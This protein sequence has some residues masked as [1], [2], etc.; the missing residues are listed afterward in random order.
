MTPVNE[1]CDKIKG[2]W[3]PEEDKRLRNLVQQHGAR[4]WSMISRSIPGRSGKSCRLRWC[5]QLSPEIEHRPFTAEEDVIILNAH[6]K[7]GNRWAKIARLINGRTDNAIKNHWNAT[8]KRKL[9]KVHGGEERPAQVLRRSESGDVAVAMMNSL[10]VSPDSLPDVCD[11]GDNLNFYLPV[12]TFARQVESPPEVV[13]DEENSEGS[14]TELTLRLPGLYRDSSA[15]E[16]R[17]EDALSTLSRR[18]SI[19]SNEFSTPLVEVKKATTSFCPEL[20]A[21]MQDMIR[22]EVRNYFSGEQL[23]LQHSVFTTTLA[24]WCIG[25]TVIS[26]RETKNQW[27]RDDPAFIVICTLLLLVSTVAYCAAYD[28]GTGHAVFVVILVLLFHFLVAGAILA[29]S[30][31]LYAFDVHCNSFFPVFVLLYVI[32]YFLS[33][34]LVAHGFVPVLL[35]NLLFMAALSYY[36]YLNYL[37]YDVLPFLERTTL[38]LYPIG[39]VIVLSPIFDYSITWRREEEF[40]EEDSVDTIS[41]FGYGRNVIARQNHCWFLVN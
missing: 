2:P 6:A 29:S 35:S 37:G 28:H 30:C 5:N 4:N 10:R 16:T 20:L 39:I 11:S 12:K 19:E 9:E 18:S 36:H 22:M 41:I 38:F 15:K 32:H 1:G 14:L 13:V 3:S 17:E 40:L 21:A 27:A 31:W 24:G 34:L 26:P 7:F 33:P 23:S 25:L 8:L